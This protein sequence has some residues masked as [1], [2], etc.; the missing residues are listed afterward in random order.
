MFCL[1]Y[2]VYYLHIDICKYDNDFALQCYCLPIVLLKCIPF[3]LVDLS[4]I[5]FSLLKLSVYCVIS[6]LK[7]LLNELFKV[8]SIWY[9]VPNY[10]IFSATRPTHVLDEV[11]ILRLKSCSF[12]QPRL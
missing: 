5:L 1:H 2:H 12:V 8:I 3:C 4:S 7:K 9:L 11:A 10:R 6:F